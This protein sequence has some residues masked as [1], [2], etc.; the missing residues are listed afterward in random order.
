MYCVPDLELY[1]DALLEL[2]ELCGKLDS[3][4]HFIILLE[5]AFDIADEHG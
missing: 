3:D 2:Y 5:A 1:L 4:R